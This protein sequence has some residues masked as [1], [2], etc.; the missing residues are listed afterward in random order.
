MIS[1]LSKITAMTTK[2]LKWKRKKDNINCG[3]WPHS[4]D[5]FVLWGFFLPN[6]WEG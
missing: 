6:K 3:L 4:D 2:S 1:L 5:L